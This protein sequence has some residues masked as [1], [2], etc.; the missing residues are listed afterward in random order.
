M[1][2]YSDF[3]SEFEVSF[4]AISSSFLEFFGDL[5][6][7]KNFLAPAKRAINPIAMNFPNL[8]ITAKKPTFANTFPATNPPIVHAATLSVLE[9]K[10]SYFAPSLY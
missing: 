3:S 4:V 8:A 9:S 1:K 5:F 6:P 2:F 10:F 7:N